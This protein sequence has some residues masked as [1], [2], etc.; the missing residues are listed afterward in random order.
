MK[1]WDVVLFILGTTWDH[2]FSFLNISFYNAHGDSPANGA[3]RN[4][5]LEVFDA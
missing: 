5:P 3:S 4:S 2:L 1:T